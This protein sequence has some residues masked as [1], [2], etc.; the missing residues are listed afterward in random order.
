[1]TE[2]RTKQASIGLWPG[3]GLHFALAVVKGFFGITAQSKALL[4]DAVYSAAH[5]VGSLSELRGAKSGR[6]VMSRDG[7][8]GRERIEP[9]ATILLAA[10]LMVGSIEI[11]VT[12]VRSMLQGVVQPPR[13]AALIV[14]V[15]SILA[16][17]IWYR[18]QLRLAH[19]E[20]NPY[21]AVIAARKHRDLLMPLVACI[22]ITGSMTAGYFGLSYFYLLD[23]VAALVITFAVLWRGYLLLLEAALRSKPRSLHMEDAQDLLATVQRIKGVISI[24]DLQAKE[25]GHYVTVDVKISVNPRISIYEGHEIA[26]TIKQVLMKRFTHIADVMVQVFPY[27]PGYPYKNADVEQ[28]DMPTLL[29]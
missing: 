20:A 14:I 17:E 6:F 12:T 18:Y 27:D 1:M 4:A 26:K 10:L 19:Q 15:I 11:A 9:M 5:V 24:D 25:Q 13:T 8:A 22:G 21:A 29:H 23:A 3:I 7:S 2:D 16:K 28:D